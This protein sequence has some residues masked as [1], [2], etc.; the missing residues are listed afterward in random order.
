MGGE[1]RRQVVAIDGPSGAGKSTVAGRL[2]QRLGWRLLDTG[3]MYRCV[4]LASLRAGLSP[5]DD[6]SLADLGA[7]LRVE[8]LP[9]R[10]LLEG[11]DVSQTIRTQEISQRSSRVAACPSVRALLVGWQRAFAAE[12]GV[13]T[14]GRDQGTV[15][16]P[17]AW[18][19]V[20]L[21][22]SPE[23]RATR[24]TEQWS[25]SGESADRDA[26]LALHSEKDQRDA[27]RTTAPMRPADDALIFD[28]TGL[29]LAQVVEILESITRCGPPYP[30]EDPGCADPRAV[31]PALASLAQAWDR[32][33]HRL[34]AVGAT[35]VDVA[36]VAG[37]TE[38]HV[39]DAST[40]APPAGSGVPLPVPGPNS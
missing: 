7:C 32:R 1:A 37:G 21:T 17:D 10:A 36:R 9:G 39:I 11:Q 30:W 25:G 40:D 6:R 8:L 20:F 2:A 23:E 14:E 4:A 33:L 15:V 13:V 34:L 22:A 38:I 24:R 28:T 29:A 26:V 35:G 5:D 27:N 16:F 12:H 31:P 18:L 19:K 3:A